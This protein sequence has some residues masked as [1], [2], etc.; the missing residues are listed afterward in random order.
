MFH[1]RPVQLWMLL[2]LYMVLASILGFVSPRSSSTSISGTF[3]HPRRADDCASDDTSIAQNSTWEKW[4]WRRNRRQAKVSFSL[5]IYLVCVLASCGS[6]EPRKYLPRI[7]TLYSRNSWCII[8]STPLGWPSSSSSASAADRD[9]LHNRCSPILLPDLW[10]PVT[11]DF[12]CSPKSVP[13]CTIF[14]L[15]DYEASLSFR[16]SL[17]LR[18]ACTPA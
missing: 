1:G 14:P 15:A 11:L 7:S 18:C 2:H 16:A 5:R 12:A 6:S 8:C 9:H 4:P 13:A 17:P 3:Y 10:F